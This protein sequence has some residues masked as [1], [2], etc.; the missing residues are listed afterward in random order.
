MVSFIPNLLEQLKN[1]NKKVDKFGMQKAI[2][3]F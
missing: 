1:I 2:S 3:A